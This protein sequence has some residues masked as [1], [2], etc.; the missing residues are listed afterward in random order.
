MGGRGTAAT[1][2]TATQS[3]GFKG[4]SV[5]DLHIAIERDYDNNE[6][7]KDYEARIRKTFNIPN[8]T[9]KQ[10]DSL[11]RIIRGMDQYDRGYDEN[12]TPYNIYHFNVEEMGGY[13][14]EQ[15]SRRK[16]LGMR[17]TAPSIYVSISTEPNVNSAY[18]RMMDAK[19]HTT[20][21]GPNGGLYEYNNNH[22]KKTLKLFNVQYGKHTM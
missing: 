15:K 2:N 9:S 4:K 20:L 11:R 8:A 10:I 7:Y 13:T 3:E 17:T 16:E 18:L 6:N 1:R 12:K 14:E 21:I 19:E 22:K 5:T